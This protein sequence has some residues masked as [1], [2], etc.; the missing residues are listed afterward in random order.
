MIYMEGRMDDQ[1]GCYDDGY[2]NAPR[3]EHLQ[4][5]RS[6]HQIPPTDAY[7]GLS[8]WPIPSFCYP[9]ICRRMK[10]DGSPLA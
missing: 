4:T 1:D 10:L 2:G 7:V 6:R 8:I 5:Q 3:Y 9:S